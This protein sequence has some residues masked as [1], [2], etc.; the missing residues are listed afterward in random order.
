MVYFL[1]EARLMLFSAV[2]NGLGY[3][4]VFDHDEKDSILSSQS[5]C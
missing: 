3:M 5:I 1:G 4:I 2:D